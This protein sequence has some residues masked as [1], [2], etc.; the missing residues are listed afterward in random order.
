L[1]SRS[2]PR[3][4]GHGGLSSSPDLRPRGR[5]YSRAACR[6]YPVGARAAIGDRSH[7]G[8]PMTTLSLVRRGGSGVSSIRSSLMQRC[9]HRALVAQC[10][11][12]FFHTLLRIT[13]WAG[14]GD[15]V[16]VRS[17]HKIWMTSA[18]FSLLELE[19]SEEDVLKLHRG[20][21]ALALKTV[22]A[23]VAALRERERITPPPPRQR[24]RKS[25][26]RRDVQRP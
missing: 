21:A 13:E 20:R 24:V 5:G 19:E 10:V 6:R 1:R 23:V 26:A 4:R 11:F 15:R 2:C 7:L 12:E 9:V 16:G 17:G 3:S 8:V 14:L 18:T 25:A 22:A